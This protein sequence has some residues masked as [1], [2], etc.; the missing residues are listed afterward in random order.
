MTL[1][2]VLDTGIWASMRMCPIGI[3]LAAAMVAL[4]ALGFG[5]RLIY[6]EVQKARRERQDT[7]DLE[8]RRMDYEMRFGAE[9]NV[10]AIRGIPFNL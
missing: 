5:A 8:R 4:G 10:R 2:E 9:S 1:G 7:R 3:V 6:L